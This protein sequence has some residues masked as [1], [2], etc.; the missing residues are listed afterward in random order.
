MRI[1]YILRRKIINCIFFW[2]WIQHYLYLRRLKESLT[3]LISALNADPNSEETCRIAESLLVQHDG[4]PD[5]IAMEHVRSE[6]GYAI[7]ELDLWCCFDDLQTN[8][9]G[10]K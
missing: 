7:E 3:P 10:E 4:S 9:R 2:R 8:S 1:F 6:T 5:W